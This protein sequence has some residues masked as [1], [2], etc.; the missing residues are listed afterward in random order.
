MHIFSECMILFMNFSICGLPNNILPTIISECPC[1]KFIVK[2]GRKKMQNNGIRAQTCYYIQQL[3]CSHG[4]LLY[5]EESVHQ[6]FLLKLIVDFEFGH[7]LRTGCRVHFPFFYPLFP[8]S[9][10]FFTFFLSF[11]SF[12]AFSFLFFTFPFLCIPL[13]NLLFE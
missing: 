6:L 11:F 5:G 13:A 12:S 8:F 4:K 9:F 2:G 10:L 1:T 3:G 7:S